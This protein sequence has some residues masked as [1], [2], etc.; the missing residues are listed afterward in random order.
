MDLTWLAPVGGI[1][2]V[3]FA[4]IFTK[5]ILKASEGTDRMKEIASAIREGANAYLKRQY[6]V[7]SVY[8]GVVFV[9]LLIMVYFKFL[10]IYNPFAFLLGGLFSESL[11][12]RWGGFEGILLL[13]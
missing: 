10:E 12:R 11:F 7:V 4:I 6:T 9:L 3:L 2:A 13:Y 5:T 1:L 8:F